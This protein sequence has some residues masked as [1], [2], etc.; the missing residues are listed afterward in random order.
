V[1]KT[2]IVLSVLFLYGC[3]ATVRNFVRSGTETYQPKP[4]DY[5]VLVFFEGD[6]PTKEFKVIG[7]VYAEKEANTGLR[8]DVVKPEEIIRLLKEEARMRGADAIIDVK[9]I[10]AEFRKRDW[11]RGEAK[12]IIF[13][14]NNITSSMSVKRALLQCS[15][16]QAA[17]D[18][19]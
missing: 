12:A 18:R 10:S 8:W 3:G 17:Q 7:M 2:L 16:G 15:Q 14:N 1:R 5:D 11:K 19:S 4:E 9:I 6:R 13:K